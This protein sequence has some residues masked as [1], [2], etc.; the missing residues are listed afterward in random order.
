M[1]LFCENDYQ[2]K[3]LLFAQKLHLHAR[4]LTVI[5]DQIYFLEVYNDKKILE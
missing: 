2:L 4:V 1:E 3:K 5:F